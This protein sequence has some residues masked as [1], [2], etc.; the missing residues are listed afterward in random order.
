[1]DVFYLAQYL[2][3]TVIQSDIL[4]AVLIL[5]FS[6]IGAKIIYFVIE[7]YVSIII[8]ATATTL[9]D[10]ILHA[11][12]KPIYLAAIIAG[13]YF[14]ILH[15]GAIEP[16]RGIVN[17]LMVVVAAIF[18]AYTLSRFINTILSWY[19]LQL[20]K[21]TKTDIDKHFIPII[22]KIVSIFL[23]VLSVVVILDQ[24][25]V[26]VT[27]LI[28]S[29]GV[30]SLAVALALQDTLSNF[31]A[32]IYIIAD[33]PIK[34]GDF[35]KLETG[36]EGFIED[37]GWRSTKVKMGSG[38]I[39]ILPN[40]K[41]AQSRVINY[42]LPA[43]ET[44]FSVQC[45]ITYDGDLEKAEKVTLRVAEKVMKDRSVKDFTPTVFFQS[46]GE[47]TIVFTVSLKASEVKEK[48]LITHDFIKALSK[49]F[50]KEGIEMSAQ[51]KKVFVKSGYIKGN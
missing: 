45:S 25:G 42:N 27:A 31:F 11:L 49:E 33:K 37:I 4:T 51:L 13:I 26:K 21:K 46:F 3:D 22:R 16:Y 30:A 15:I 50:R 14:S 38:N 19:A 7:K 10:E 36:E 24:L 1:M 6:V 9:D 40:S 39:L 47:S 23:Y 17:K 20:A 8:R 12:K 2:Y 35:V 28:A 18:G 34:P 29:L 5:V 43:K 48:G 32:G 44:C 41:M